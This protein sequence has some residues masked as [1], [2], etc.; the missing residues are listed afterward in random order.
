MVIRKQIEGNR[1]GQRV[2]LDKIHMERL[3]GRSYLIWTPTR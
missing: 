3:A 2:T 1:P